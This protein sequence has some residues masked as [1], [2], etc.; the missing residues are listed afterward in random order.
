MI[1][2]EAYMKS[3]IPEKF[4]LHVITFFNV[5]PNKLARALRGD[6]TVDLSSHY[7]SLQE[8]SME[9]FNDDMELAD[10][11][12]DEMSELFSHY[13]DLIM[14]IQRD[15]EL[16]QELRQQPSSGSDAEKLFEVEAALHARRRQLVTEYQE[17]VLLLNYDYL[18]LLQ[19]CQNF[20]LKGTDIRE[21]FFVYALKPVVSEMI[22]DYCRA[23]YVERQLVRPG[24]DSL[25]IVDSK[26]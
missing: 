5:P 3:Y 17:Q 23:C 16:T 21:K 15:Q 12:S 24:E 4:R 8:I 11:T 10:F 25:V 26:S 6:V 22:Y 19:K 20:P 7:K 2:W 14:E 18:E 1:A 9:E 13:N